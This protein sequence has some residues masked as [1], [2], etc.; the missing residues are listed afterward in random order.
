MASVAA[1]LLSV[2]A[3]AVLLSVAAAAVLLSVAAALMAA[4]AAQNMA[5]YKSQLAELT[6]IS[7]LL[8]TQPTAELM[9]KQAK[10]Q[11]SVNMLGQKIGVAP[12]QQARAPQAGMLP[13]APAPAASHAVGHY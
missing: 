9:Q 3:A 13:P 10:L 4:N 11:Y 1:L 2:A 7:T 6:R 12:P 5:E 8:Q